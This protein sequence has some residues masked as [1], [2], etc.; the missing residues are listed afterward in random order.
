MAKNL[1]LDGKA[2]TIKRVW[3][4]KVNG[5]LRLLGIPTMEDRAKQCLVKMALE[6]EW[7]V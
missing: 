1:I 4:P 2:S 7:E 3:I 5:K 6:P